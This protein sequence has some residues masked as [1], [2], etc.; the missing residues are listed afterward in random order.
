MTVSPMH[1]EMTSAGSKSHARVSVVNNS[2][3]PLPIEAVLQRLTLDESGKSKLTKAGEDFL[4]MPPQAMIP[5]GA[6]QNFR[7]QWLGDPLM[8]KS[9]SFILQLNQIPVKMAPGQSGVQVVMSMGV[10]LNVAPVNGTPALNLISTSV[11]QSKSGKRYLSVLVQNPSATHALI[12]QSTLRLQAGSW[13]Q[14]LSPGELGDRVGIGLVQP[15]RRRKFTFPIDVPAG[16]DRV[17]ASIEF[18]SRR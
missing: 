1:V 8:Q 11:S 7:I 9:E 13:S 12:S 6:T 10:M 14:T 15:G 3:T 17:A 18:P 4:V 16:F 2:N 5:P